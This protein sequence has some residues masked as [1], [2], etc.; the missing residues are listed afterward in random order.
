MRTSTSDK[1]SNIP[2]RDLDR[3]GSLLEG[4][5]YF[6]NFKSDY[7]WSHKLPLGGTSCQYGDE[8][9]ENLSIPISKLLKSE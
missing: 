8:K 3:R 4:S 2:L 1:D 6:I 9:G 5:V 7:Q